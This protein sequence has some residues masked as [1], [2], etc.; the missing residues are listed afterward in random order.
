MVGGDG[1]RHGLLGP[2]ALGR[3]AVHRPDLEGV[4][5]VGLQVVDGHAGSLQAQLLGAE[6]DAVPAGLA[7]PALGPAALA[8]HVVGEVLASSRAQGGAPLQVDRGLV[9]VGDEIE[10]C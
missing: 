8:H 2:G 4:V 5:G 6:V 9:H 1:H 10:R 7:A 3:H